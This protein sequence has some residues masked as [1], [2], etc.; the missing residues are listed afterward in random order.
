VNFGVKLFVLVPDVEGR[1][2]CKA[3]D[4]RLRW[5]KN[6][7]YEDGGWRVEVC[8]EQ[9]SCMVA[10]A[11]MDLVSRMKIA[12]PSWVLEVEVGA[13]GYARLWVGKGPIGRIQP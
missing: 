5:K 7:V 1:W 4:V 2:V 10:G 3:M 11:D 6:N 8:R 12:V 9:I 13:A